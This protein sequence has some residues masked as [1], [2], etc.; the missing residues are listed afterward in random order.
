MLAFHP[1]ALAGEG[2]MGFVH[3]FVHCQQRANLLSYARDANASPAMLNSL[4][5]IS[6][7]GVLEETQRVTMESI[8]WSAFMLVFAFGIPVSVFIWIVVKHRIKRPWLM[9]LVRAATVALFITPNMLAD[10]DSK[11]GVDVLHWVPAVMRIF[12]HQRI[13]TL[14][15]LLSIGMMTLFLWWLGTLVSHIAGALRGRR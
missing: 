14:F 5:R 8:D 9:R 7:F 3:L 12:G 1:R 15:S 4:W 13:Y 6:M 2:R 10:L 11:G